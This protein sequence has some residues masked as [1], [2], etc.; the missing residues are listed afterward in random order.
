LPGNPI[1]PGI[2]RHYKG[3][4]YRVLGAG[5]HTETEEP[6]VLYYQLDAPLKLFARPA[7]MFEETVDYDGK[8]H[9]RFTLI[10]LKP[11]AGD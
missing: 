1:S 9:S 11:V 4:L 7:A 10:E 5:I 2:Y 6:L 8:T 3:T